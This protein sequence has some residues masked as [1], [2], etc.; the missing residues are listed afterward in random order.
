MVWTAGCSRGSDQVNLRPL[1]VVSARELLINDAAFPPSWDADPCAPD[2]DRAEGER[3][4][5]RTFGLR[6]TAAK[7]TQNV[8]RLPSVA[9][10]HATF[11]R[12]RAVDFRTGNPLREPS[13]DLIPPPEITYQSPLADEYYFGCGVDVIPLCQVSTRYGQYFIEFFFY[14][15][16]GVADGVVIEEKGGLDITEVEPILRAL[17]DH[18]GARLGLP[19]QEPTVTRT[20]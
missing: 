19:L 9:E 18:V 16:R 14:M 2:C 5:G 17:D 6:A 10:A 3:K 15:E 1:V 4:A 8:S 12:S 13:S 11:E 7:A 20:D